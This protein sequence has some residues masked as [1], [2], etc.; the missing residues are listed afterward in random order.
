MIIG[1]ARPEKKNCVDS[2]T[3]KELRDAF[4]LFEGD[5]YALSCVL[6]GKGGTFCAGYDLGE[7]AALDEDGGAKLRDRITPYHEGHAP[8]VTQSSPHHV[9]ESCVFGDC[10][11]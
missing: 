3:A 1:I 7:L 8:M 9:D 11:G 2:V 10:H 5:E 6:H 4:T